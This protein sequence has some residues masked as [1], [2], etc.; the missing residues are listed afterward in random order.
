MSKCG[1]LILGC[2]MGVILI[3]VG[4]EVAHQDGIIILGA[5]LLASMASVLIVL[6]VCNFIGYLRKKKNNP[7]EKRYLDCYCIE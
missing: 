1:V 6:G 5:M 7:C 2:L 3:L 4:K